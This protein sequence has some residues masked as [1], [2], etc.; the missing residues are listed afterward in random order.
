M[1]I[2]VQFRL[3]F[4]ANFISVKKIFSVKRNDSEF[5]RNVYYTQKYSR[6]KIYGDQIYI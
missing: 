1:S 4:Y 6:N 5:V 2:S 3:K